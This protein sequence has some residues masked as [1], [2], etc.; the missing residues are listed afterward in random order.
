MTLCRCSRETLSLTVSEGSE[1][2]LS[3]LGGPCWEI[4]EKLSLGSQ[5][6]HCR[7]LVTLQWPRG[8]KAQVL[9]L[10]RNSGSAV[11]GEEG[12]RVVL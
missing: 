6:P 5:L 3:L 2:V 7:V 11:R 4:T 8:F 9:D 1:A 10:G 12:T